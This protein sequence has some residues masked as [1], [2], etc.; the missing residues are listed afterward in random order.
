MGIEGQGVRRGN[1]VHPRRPGS[2]RRV[3]VSGGGK[4]DLALAAGSDNNAADHMR[5]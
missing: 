5:C 3:A 2:G 4:E 1:S